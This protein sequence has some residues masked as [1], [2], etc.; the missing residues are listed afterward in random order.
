MMN[1]ILMMVVDLFLIAS[2]EVSIMILKYF[3]HYSCTVP[4]A[5]WWIPVRGKFWLGV[6]WAGTHIKKEGKKKII[7]SFT[8]APTQ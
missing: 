4:T 7:L 3:Q 8:Y 5:L 1:K 6:G 2:G